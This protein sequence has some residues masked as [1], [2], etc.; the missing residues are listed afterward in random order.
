MKI[1]KCKVLET[2]TEGIFHKWCLIPNS[3][4]YPWV[5]GLIDLY[6]SYAS[7]HHL[8][9][10]SHPFGADSHAGVRRSNEYLGLT[11]WLCCQAHKAFRK[12]IGG[13]SISARF[14][15]SESVLGPIACVDVMDGAFGFRMRWR[16]GSGDV[17]EAGFF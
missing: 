13:D 7:L 6:G 1:N 9:T 8:A 17:G 2:F 11:K 5:L 15:N 12:S 3:M 16:G 10:I 14:S 4:S